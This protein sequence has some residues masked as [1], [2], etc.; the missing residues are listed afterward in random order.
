M[1][2]VTAADIAAAEGGPQP[3]LDL[4]SREAQ[5]GLFTPATRRAIYA[6]L[7]NPRN[8]TAL[9]A[10]PSPRAA[11]AAARGDG[12]ATGAVGSRGLRRMA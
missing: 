9:V 12:A 2:L 8:P 11:A 7:L 6:I 4:S 3:M 1:P 10:A 5:V